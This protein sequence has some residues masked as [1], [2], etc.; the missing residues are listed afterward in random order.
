M[1]LEVQIVFSEFE[2]GTRSINAA[3]VNARLAQV[4]VDVLIDDELGILIYQF[5]QL[6]ARVIKVVTSFLCGF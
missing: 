4:S 5:G 2:T 6:Y 3:S 1:R